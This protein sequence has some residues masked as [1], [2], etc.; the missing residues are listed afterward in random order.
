MARGDIW[1]VNFPVPSGVP[2]REQ[3]GCRPAIIV[4]TDAL[5]AGLSTVMVVPVT[6][7]LN[8]LRFPHN[9]RVDPSPQNGLSSAS[10]LMVC[11]L[12]AIDKNRL[13][14]NIGCLEQHHLQQLETEIRGLLGL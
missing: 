13:G 14:N 11:Q 3:Q 9:F 5:D 12:R 7:K 8:A 4:Q 10:V 1:T 2:G 6:S